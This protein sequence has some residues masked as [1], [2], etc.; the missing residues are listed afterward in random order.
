MDRTVESAGD[1]VVTARA[2]TRESFAPYGRLL[3][4][5]DRVHLGSRG[6]VVVAVDD[7]RPGP[8][9][10]THLVRYP[11]ARRVLF[12]LRDD[13]SLLLVV[14]PPGEQ[15]GGPPVAF[16]IPEGSGVMLLAGTW[17]AGPA[18]LADVPVLELLETTGPVDRFDRRSLEDL[19][20]TPGVR[21]LLPEEPGAPG[22]GLDLAAPGAVTVAP[23][24][25]DRVRL[26]CAT[27]DR[28]QVPARSAVLAGQEEAATAHLRETW[29]RVRD[30][31]QVPGIA[32]GRAVFQALGVPPG[33]ERPPGEAA[34]AVLLNGRGLER[35]NAL[36][37]AVRL[38]ALTTRRVVTV[39]DAGRAGDRL[40][41]RLED[42]SARA[43]AGR[44]V[45]VD[46]EGRLASLTEVYA[47]TRVETATTRALLVL[48]LPADEPDPVAVSLLDE[49][50]QAVRSVCGGEETGRL[51]TR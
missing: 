23:P 11:E 32:A 18:P 43:D 6:P 20:G 39:H 33:A 21:V 22:T 9:R 12:P 45:L 24:L 13:A 25:R 3:R 4:R 35:R 34:L 26:A 2:A 29:G 44:A 5:G 8:R 10:T 14:L 37:D 7:A 16:R 36:L 48:W 27:I 49:V 17:H 41:L 19:I 42:E 15:P 46:R 28:L 31:T 40:V 38:V 50:V 30:L 47:R 51:V 1:A